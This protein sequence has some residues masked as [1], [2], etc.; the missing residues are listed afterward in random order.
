MKEND[1][2]TDS[3]DIEESAEIK[4][5]LNELKNGSSPTSNLVPSASFINKVV[6]GIGIKTVVAS[7]GAIAGIAASAA[8]SNAAGSSVAV[9]TASTATIA[10]KTVVGTIIALL[11][12]GA[13]AYTSSNKN[14]ISSLKNEKSEEAKSQPRFHTK[15]RLAL[16]ILIHL[17]FL[18]LFYHMYYTKT[19]YPSQ[20]ETF[21]HNEDIYSFVD[22][23]YILQY[24]PI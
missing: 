13:I 2:I 19:Y 8:G 14:L 22:N 10:V 12:A 16:F 15:T 11:V 21:L 1:I 4:S 6:T 18:K 7:S 24:F 5:F 20:L 3:F 23:L 17:Y 9:A